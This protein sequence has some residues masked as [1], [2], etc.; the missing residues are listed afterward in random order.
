MNI[1]NVA[2]KKKLLS[3]L[4]TALAKQQKNNAPGA[5]KAMASFISL[6]TKSQRNETIRPADANALTVAA[7]QIRA[8]IG[9]GG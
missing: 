1:S 2:V 4:S 8:V 3:Y 7:T 9:C 6:T 5:C